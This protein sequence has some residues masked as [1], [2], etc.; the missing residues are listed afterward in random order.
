MQGMANDTHLCISNLCMQ[1][2]GE[3][4]VL[5]ELVAQLQDEIPKLHHLMIMVLQN[6]HGAR[7]KPQNRRRR[8]ECDEGHPARCMTPTWRTTYISDL[9]DRCL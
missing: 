7:A 2:D 6:G 8:G 5:V 3:V 9:G 4:S 1:R